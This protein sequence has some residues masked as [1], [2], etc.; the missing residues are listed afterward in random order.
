MRP[1]RERGGRSRR[2]DAGPERPHHHRGDHP[3]HRGRRGRAPRGDVRAAVLILLGEEPMHG[4]QLMHAI[5]DRSGGRWTPSPGAIYPTLSQLEDEGLVTITRES[6]RKLAALTDQGRTV[7]E[8]EDNPVADP[9]ATGE[10]E[11]PV[12]DLRDLMG[13]RG[14]AGR[15]VAR[16]GTPEQQATAAA[17]LAEARKSIYLLLAEGPS[18]PGE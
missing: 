18:A 9:F 2:P 8:D 10:G 15:Q 5:A 13:Q 16:A 14:G 1:P 3:H 4:Y 7:L 6:G 12:V 11:Q 17:T